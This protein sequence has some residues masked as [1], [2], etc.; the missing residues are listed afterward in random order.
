[1]GKYLEKIN[2]IFN[3]NKNNYVML[4]EK[5]YLTVTFNLDKNREEYF[6][7]KMIDITF[8]NNYDYCLSDI[9]EKLLLKIGLGINDVVRIDNITYIGDKDDDKYDYVVEFSINGVYL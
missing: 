6:L 3:K 8:G 4:E 9:I 7:K 5:K 2:A 1:M